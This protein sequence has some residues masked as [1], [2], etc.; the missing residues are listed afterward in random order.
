MRVPSVGVAAPGA[1]VL[2]AVEGWGSIE[3]ADAD[4]LT[5]HGRTRM[6]NPARRQRIE[7]MLAETPHDAELHYMLAMEHVSAGDDAGAVTVFRELI[8][9][10][11]EKPYVPAFLMAGQALIRLGQDAEAVAMLRSG[12]EAARKVGDTHALSEMEGLLA[13]I[14]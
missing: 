13:T 9:R 2:R 12:I 10:H 14:E 5:R 1:P 3:Y 7:A 8:A 11:E 6:S 4:R